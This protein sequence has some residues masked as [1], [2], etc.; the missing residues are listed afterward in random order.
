MVSVDEQLALTALAEIEGK[1]ITDKCAKEL[2]KVYKELGKAE[3]EINQCTEK[4]KIP[5]EELKKLFRQAKK[6]PRE[7]KKV[8]KKT[9]IS[10]NELLAYEKIIKNARKRIRIIEAESTFNAH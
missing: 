9:G 10:Q 7:A 4:T 5:L 8:V 6:S 3:E 1:C 2:D